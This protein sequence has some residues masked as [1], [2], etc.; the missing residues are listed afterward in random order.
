[1]TLAEENSDGQACSAQVRIHASG[2]GVCAL[3][4]ATIASA[5][6]ERNFIFEKLQV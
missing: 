1:M 4:T 5:D 2:V 3:T 6:N